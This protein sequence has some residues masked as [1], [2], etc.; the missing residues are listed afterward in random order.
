MAD[1]EWNQMDNPEP[2]VEP[3]FQHLMDQCKVSLE[4]QEHLLAEGF[5]S[6]GIFGFA[7]NSAESFEEYL[8]SIVQDKDLDE[9]WLRSPAAS[10]LRFLFHRSSQEMRLRTTLRYPQW[11]VF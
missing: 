2:T 8:K 4:L 7:F 11:T 1:A 10:S 6:I 9:N 3:D 5:T